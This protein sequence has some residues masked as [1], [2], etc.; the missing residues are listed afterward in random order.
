MQQKGKKKILESYIND[1]HSFFKRKVCGG[2]GSW[3]SF[4]FLLS[5]CSELINLAYPNSKYQ[6]IFSI[7]QS[8]SFHHSGNRLG[9]SS[10]MLLPKSQ[11]FK[12]TRRENFNHRQRTSIMFNTRIQLQHLPKWNK[13]KNITVLLLSSIVLKNPSISYDFFWVPVFFFLVV[14]ICS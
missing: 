7:K 3:T 11:E 5:T 6:W 13:H 4:K 8:K 2:G 10:N 9:Y 12:R 14:T 1:T